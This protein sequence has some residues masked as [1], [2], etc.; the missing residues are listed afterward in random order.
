MTTPGRDITLAAQPR[1]LVGADRALAGP[2]PVEPARLTALQDLLAGYLLSKRSA[3]RTAYA[4]DLRSWLA[5]CTDRGVDPLGAGLHHADA[6]LRTLDEVGDPATGRRLAPSTIARRVSAVH[7][8]YRYAVAHQAVTGSPFTAATRPRVDGESMTSGLTRTQVLALM[9]TAAE[10]SPRS[11]ALV[12]LLV[13]N[14]LRITEALAARVEDLDHDRGHRVLRIT[15]KGGRRAKVPLTPAVQRA[16]D[17]ATAGRSAGPLFVTASGKALDRT[18]AWRLLRRLATTAG[19]PG[20]HRI[21]P[22]SMRHTF[23]TTALDAGVPLRDVQDSLGHADPRTTRLYDRTRANLDRN[24]AYAVA[25]H[26]S[27]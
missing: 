4:A 21:S 24:A 5:W 16:I 20:A 14:G 23:A 17:A 3:T 1:P 13:L 6:Y 22:H 8:F 15:R 11:E 26:L 2:A 18:A 27:P 7:G 12:A 25:A 9:R 19:I 10:H